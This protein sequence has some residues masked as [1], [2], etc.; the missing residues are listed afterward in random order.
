MRSRAGGGDA[1]DF[2]VQFEGLAGGQVP[3]E[4]VLL[5]E[6]QGELPAVAVV[7]FP[8]DVAEHAGRAAGGVEQAGQ[9]FQGG[10]LARAVGAEKA[11][12]FAGLDGEADV[13]D[14]EGLLVLPAEKAADRAAQSPAASCKCG[15]PWSGR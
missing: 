15:R 9:H 4:L 13:L 6:Q 7:A 12:Q 10:G 2:G 11:D 14:G 1:V 3:P 5:A 8:G